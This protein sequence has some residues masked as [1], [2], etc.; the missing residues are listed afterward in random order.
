MQIASVVSL[1]PG[2][3]PAQAIAPRSRIVR[4][5]APAAE[6]TQVIRKSTTAVT[7]CAALLCTPLS[8]SIACLRTRLPAARP[9]FSARALREG[10]ICDRTP[11]S[12]PADALSQRAP[13]APSADRS[14]SVSQD[15]TGLQ[16]EAFHV[17]PDQI[18]V[19]HEMLISREHYRPRRRLTVLLIDT[20]LSGMW[21]WLYGC[22]S[23]YICE[24]W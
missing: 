16:D 15:A 23:M 18:E 14:A 17:A 4:S 6:C 13:A 9:N 21:C 3:A 10:A 11:I 22:V 8:G 19:E 20:S 2:T 24:L 1:C 7:A 5:T 12:K